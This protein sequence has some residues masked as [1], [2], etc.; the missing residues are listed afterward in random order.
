M[1]GRPRSPST[2]VALGGKGANQAVAAARLSAAGGVAFVGQFGGDAHAAWLEQKLAASGVDV[3]ACGRHA[4]LQSGQGYVLLEPDGAASS[5]VVS[6]ANGAWADAHVAAVCDL[7]RGAAVVLLQREVP[8]GVNEAVA[9]AC[10]AA[11]VPVIQDVGG[12]ERP[13]AD[14]HL[15]NCA[16][17]CPNLSELERLSGGAPGSLASDDDAV[18]AAAKALQARGA[19]SVLV[20]LGAEGSLLLLDDGR[21]LRQKR[22]RAAGGR[23]RRHRRRR[24]VSRRLRRRARR[25]PPARAVP[26]V[27]RRRRRARRLPPRRRAEPAGPRRRPRPLRTSLRRAAARRRGAAAR[28][29][30]AGG[31]AG[32]GRRGAGR[33]RAAAADGRGCRAARRRRGRAAERAAAAVAA[34]RHRRRRGGCSLRRASTP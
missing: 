3:A 9:A 21:I 30:G 28:R 27:W 12:E 24:R 33:R 7:A 5:V 25:G 13:I 34:A 31:G 15:A 22:R 11:G 1:D 19:R 20:T 4:E 2:A 29:R 32:G 8:E 14:A 6:G 16:F 26:P 18:V 23:R 10:A 17:V